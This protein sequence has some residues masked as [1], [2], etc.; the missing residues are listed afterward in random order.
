MFNNK[1]KTTIEGNLG[2]T[3]RLVESTKIEG[4]ISSNADIRIDGEVKGNVICKGKVVLG[5]KGKIEGTLTCMNA[6]IEGQIKGKIIVTE[7]LSIKSKANIYGDVT[8]GKLAVEPGA[9]FT[10]TCIMNAPVKNLNPEVVKEKS[11]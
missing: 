4:D 3:N 10:A 9:N 6:D 5:S 1:L 2:A 8:V 7:L 11:A